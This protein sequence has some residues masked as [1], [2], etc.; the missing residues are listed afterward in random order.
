MDKE[1]R[2]STA[3][4]LLPV[5]KDGKEGQRGSS[6]A[7]PHSMP[8]GAKV[9]SNLELS[10]PHRYRP[11]GNMVGTGWFAHPPVF[12]ALFLHDLG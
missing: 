2:H 1:T 5:F 12:L 7:G 10:V 3:A 4:L 11:G 9:S 8:C 6:K